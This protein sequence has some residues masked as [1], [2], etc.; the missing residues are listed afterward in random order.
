MKKNISFTI[1]TLSIVISLFGLLSC[2]S[3][4][5][6]TNTR[7]TSQMAFRIT[8]SMPG[9]NQNPYDEVGWLHNELLGI[10]YTGDT[11]ANSVADITAKIETIAESNEDFKTLQGTSYH[12]ISM[13]RVRYILDHQNTCVSD[14]ISGSSMTSPAKTSL[15]SFVNSVISLSET[16]TDTAT[17]YDYIVNYESDILNNTLLSQTDKRILLITSSIARHTTYLYAKRPKKNTDPDWHVL[18]GNIIAATDGAEYG[19]AEAVVLALVT[20]IAQN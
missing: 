4:N 6:M 9:N 15:I 13:E 18:V 11:L 3:D 10:Y 8:D 19:S 7:Q 16:E 20:G 1:V 14:I 2:N 17:F 12:S 5:D